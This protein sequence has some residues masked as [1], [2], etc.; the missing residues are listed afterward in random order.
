MPI[1]ESLRGHAAMLL[2]AALIS[3]SF[4]L[5]DLAVPHISPGSLTVARFALAVVVMG[6]L[7]SPH[8][9]AA[10][11]RALWRFPI[12][13]GLMAF[14]FILMF[15]ALEITD[16]VST[17]A[18]FTLTPLMSAVFGYILMRQITTPVMAIALLLAGMG[19]IWVILRGDIQAILGLRLGLGEKIFLIG[20]AAHALYTPLVRMT[21]R[22]EPVIVYTFATL[23]GGLLVTAVYSAQE[24]L[25]TDWLALP[26]IAW[27]GIV[28]LGLFTTAGTFLLIQFATMRLP[29]AKVMAYGYLV[30]TFVIIQE[31][32]LGHGWVAAPVWLGVAA[33]FGALLILLK[34]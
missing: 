2:F 27:A 22:D 19:A 23:V 32:L 13:G 9:R 7:A 11:F 10:H 30:P 29:S 25:A 5:G 17:G 16:P 6:I 8:M 15:E 28:Y 21:R 1:S 3:V 18:V 4:T 12:L 33:T 34:D 31:G 20:C 24:S 14:Y 26:V